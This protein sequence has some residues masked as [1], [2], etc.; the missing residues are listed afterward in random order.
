MK[1][2]ILVTI[3]IKKLRTISIEIHLLTAFI[4]KQRYQYNAYDNKL[5]KL[6]N[7]EI[8]YKYLSIIEKIFN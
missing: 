6:N 4:F 3:I 8:K 7:F 2:N 1:I 5:I